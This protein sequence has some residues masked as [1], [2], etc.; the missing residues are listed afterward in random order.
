MFTRK[1]AALIGLAAAGALAL[2]ACE[3]ASGGGG[4]GSADDFP[5]P[6]EQAEPPSPIAAAAAPGHGGDHGKG[7]K[8]AGAEVKE[9][10]DVKAQVE[11][12]DVEVEG[13]EV[14]NVRP[15][16]KAD[17]FKTKLDIGNGKADKGNTFVNIPIGE[18]AKNPVKVAV[19]NPPAKVK[20][21]K[22]FEVD[23]LVA[24]KDG[25]LDLNAFT[26]D[27]SGGAGVTFLE[28]PGELDKDGRP[29]A[30]CHIGAVTLDKDGFPA[31]DDY[32][33]AFSGVQGVKGDLTAKID[34]LN[35]GSYR[36]DVWCSQPG[37]LVLP[38]NKAD[39]VQAI[40][41]FRFEVK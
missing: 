12:A 8:V 39:K 9:D 16:A 24:D 18:V 3:G 41:S 28:H 36:A 21:G 25:A 38:T 10:D 31:A 33:A 4:Y 15:D 11:R 29:L 17:N 30:H 32:D 35:A 40:D 7:D 27:E 2:A 26:F 20:A 22:A 19:K 23:V 13:D 37:H 14:D 1:K 6:A 5:R 34:G